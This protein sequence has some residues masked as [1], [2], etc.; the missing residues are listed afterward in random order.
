MSKIPDNVLNPKLYKKAKEE[1]DKKF[2]DKT[3]AYKSMWIS[4]KYKDLGGKY[5]GKKKSLTSRWRDEKWIQIEPYIKD[6]KK[7]VCGEDNTQNKACRPLIKVNQL[8]PMTMD[9]IIKKHGKKKVL[10]LV[11]K[12]QNDME[13]R[14]LWTTG[15]FLPSRGKG[16]R[17]TK[18]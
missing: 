15:T 10:E 16:D 13:G 18:K 7:I 12:K 4:K 11:N 2:E 5:S 1:A 14:L 6:N 3:S 17:Q 9:E 8:T